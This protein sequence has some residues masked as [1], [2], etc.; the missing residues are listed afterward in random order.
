[1]R[2]LNSA[3][4]RR[5]RDATTSAAKSQTQHLNYLLHMLRHCI[6]QNI[7]KNLANFMIAIYY[8]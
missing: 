7:Y 4:W 5:L 8:E 1:M 2:L 6:L 3:S